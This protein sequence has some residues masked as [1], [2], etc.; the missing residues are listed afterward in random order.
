MM[1][2]CSLNKYIKPFLSLTAMLVTIII[3]TLLLQTES[4]I[5]P[6][7]CNVRIHN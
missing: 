4:E 7:L 6:L 3:M 5:G 2:F 1:H